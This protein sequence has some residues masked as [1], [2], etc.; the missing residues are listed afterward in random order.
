MH[1]ICPGNLKFRYA[2]FY[3]VEYLVSILSAQGERLLQKTDWQFP[4]V[5]MRRT[6][7]RF[8]KFPVQI[9]AAFA[10][11]RGIIFNEKNKKGKETKLCKHF[12]TLSQA[13]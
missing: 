1:A 8:A 3:P 13:H 12:T 11:G 4:S 9:A 7:R 5:R 6:S 10:P 2:H